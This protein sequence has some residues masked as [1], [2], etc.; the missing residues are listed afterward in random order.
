MVVD[1]LLITGAGAAVVFTDT[2]SKVAVARLEV[3]TLLTP[4]PI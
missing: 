4:K 2:L 1:R 3:L